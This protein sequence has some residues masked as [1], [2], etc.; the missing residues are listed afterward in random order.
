MLRFGPFAAL[1]LLAACSRGP[2]LPPPSPALWEVTGANGAHGWL[3]GTAHSLPDG[4]DWRTAAIDAA[5]ADAATLVVEVDLDRA[6]PAYYSR[7]ATTKGLGAPSARVDPAFRVRLAAVIAETGHSEDEFRDTESWAVALTLAGAFRFGE[8]AN[9]VD[10]DLAGR[11]GGKRLVELEGYRRQLDIFDRL[12]QAEQ[13]DMLEVVAAE[14]ATAKPEGERQTKA[15]RLG[16]TATIE[17]AM[18]TGLL[19]DPELR[20]ALL[21]GRNEAWTQKIDRLLKDDARPFVAVGAAHLLGEDGLP[22]MLEERG[23]T[24]K[25]VQ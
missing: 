11:R 20:A 4:Y 22:A 7:L 25:R 5:F 21:T 3:F 19:A 10:R 18:R 1:L 16:D 2:D 6:D 14:A 9:G 24:V 13:A 8:S 23:Y 15:W 12:P 17:A